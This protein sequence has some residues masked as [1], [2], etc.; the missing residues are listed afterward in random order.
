MGVLR[1][2]IE[3]SG[4][5]EHGCAIILSMRC[6]QHAPDAA[7]FSPHPSDPQVVREGYAM[8]HARLEPCNVVVLAWVWLVS[9][10]SF[11]RADDTTLC[12]SM[13]TG[14]WR[15]AR[16]RIVHTDSVTQTGRWQP[17]ICVRGNQVIGNQVIDQ[18]HL[19]QSVPPDQ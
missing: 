9:V 14:T 19:D 11:R 7:L 10:E 3:S 8:F 6:L 18:C 2:S 13:E 16:Y 4:S 5:G 1:V 12:G 17:G 15:H